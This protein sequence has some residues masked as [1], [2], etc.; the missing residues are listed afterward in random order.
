MPG[1]IGIQTISATPRD[2]QQVRAY[3]E[4]RQA[5]KDGKL[6]TDTPLPVGS[7]DNIWWAYGHGSWTADP[8][9]KSAQDACCLPFGGGY[10]A[11]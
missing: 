7:H 4:G 6:I 8:A 11:P 3:C 5:A 10:V 2:P 9:G 1:K